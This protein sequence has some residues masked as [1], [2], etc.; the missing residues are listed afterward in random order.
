MS[1]LRFSTVLE[2]Y[3]PAA[4]IMLTEELVPSLGGAKNAP[5]IVRIGEPGRRVV[6]HELPL[7]WIGMT[8]NAMAP[9]EE[10]GYWHAH[11]R[12]EELYVFLAGRG[13][14]ALDDDVVDVG[15]GTVIRVGTG[16]WRTWRCD[17]AGT[18]LL[19]WLCIRAGPQQLA[20]V[21]DDAEP[22]TDRPMPW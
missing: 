10:A 5:V 20:R 7:E 19:R 22:V 17:P 16:V 8:A 1:A 13:Q 9:G 15:P 12:D 11:S 3:G 2:P 21:P 6:D 4:A 14:M 18:E